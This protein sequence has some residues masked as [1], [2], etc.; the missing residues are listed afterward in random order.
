MVL[1][2]NRNGSESSELKVV[3]DLRRSVS[4]QRKQKLFPQGKTRIMRT[5]QIRR[6]MWL[7]ASGIFFLSILV[8]IA[9]RTGILNPFRPA[10][11]DALS[12]GRLMVLAMTS[13]NSLTVKSEESADAASNEVQRR[14]ETLLRQFMIEN[15]RL[16]RDL[17]REQATSAIMQS[18]E[19]L[20]SLAQFELLRASVISSGGMPNSLR[21]LIVD[22]GKAAGITRS[23]LVIAGDGILLDV[24]SDSSVAAGDRVLTGAIVVGRVDKAARWVSLVQ[25]VT[26]VGFKSQVILLRQTPDGPHFG[27]EGMLEGTGNAECTLTGIPHTDAVAVGDEVVSADVNGL[28]GPRL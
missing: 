20:N 8:T 5:D 1:D 2:L 21:D 19:P 6:R 12:P 17:K 24:G 14:N 10:L 16:R 26:A 13:Q 3:R 15:A 11:H 25:P 9:D 22:A 18:F 4:Q 23:E 7:S 27:A 28:R